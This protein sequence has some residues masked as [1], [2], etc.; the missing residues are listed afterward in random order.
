MV[1]IGPMR[2]QLQQPGLLL[3]DLAVGCRHQRQGHRGIRHRCGRSVHLLIEHTFT[4]ESSTDSFVE[5][6]SR[7]EGAVRRLRTHAITRHQPA[8]R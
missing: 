8:P 6:K 5:D 3:D 7:F 1:E 4:L 2:R